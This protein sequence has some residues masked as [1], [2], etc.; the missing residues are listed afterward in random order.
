MLE[1]L[2]HH[3]NKVFSITDL[4]LLHF[5]L[6]LE[7]HYSHQGIILTQKYSS[8]LLRDGG[9]LQFKRVS[10]PLPLY[11]KLHTDVSHPYEIQPGINV[12]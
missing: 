12:L 2:K 3:L 8:E 4:G 10:T 5:F 9:I 6:G 11:V 7:V 1:D